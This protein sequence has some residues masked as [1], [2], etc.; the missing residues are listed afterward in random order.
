LPT[1]LRDAREILVALDTRREDLFLQRFDPQLRAIGSAWLATPAEAVADLPAIPWLVAGDGLPLLA[2]VL[3]R[4][5]DIARAPGPGHI[6]AAGFV[7]VAAR[8]LAEGGEG[9]AGPLLLPEPFY[10]RA[11]DVKLPAGLAAP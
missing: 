3:P 5:R 2:P 10:L 9:A 1:A 11:P 6:E 8:L 4:D 7:A